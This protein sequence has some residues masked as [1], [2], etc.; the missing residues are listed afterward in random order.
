MV[1]YI[2]EW[3]T[4]DVDQKYRF[5]YW[6]GAICENFIE[7]TLTTDTHESFS[8]KLLSMDFSVLSLSHGT[9]SSYKIVRNN[10]D[11]SKSS[12]A[13][14]YLICSPDSHCFLNHNNQQVHLFPGDLAILDTRI[15]FFTDFPTNYNL[16]TVTIPINW[17]ETW[18]PNITKYIGLRIDGSSSW[19]KILSNFIFQLDCSPIVLQESLY[20]DQIGGLI[21]LALNQTKSLVPRSHINLVAMIDTCIQNRFTEF[22]LTAQDIAVTLNISTRTLHRALTNNGR[23]FAFTLTQLRLQAAQRMLISPLYKN[24]T[25]AEI[26]YRTGWQ[27]TSHFA[28]V[29]RNWTNMSPSSSRYGR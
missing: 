4:D 24:L 14:Y 8:A 12:I 15:P 22:G 16:L 27:N 20:C 1:D 21:S 18:L 3:N 10:K 25:I 29:Y 28:R 11:I 26:C 7:E 23:T 13:C 9:G 19:G 5:D 17:F 6:V 2:K